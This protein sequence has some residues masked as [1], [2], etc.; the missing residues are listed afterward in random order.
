MIAGSDTTAI[1]LYWSTI[2]LA[3]YPE[4][5][6][7]MKDEVSL[8]WESTQEKPLFQAVSEST[9]MNAFIKEVVRMYPPAGSIVRRLSEEEEEIWGIPVPDQKLTTVAY[10]MLCAHRRE[11]YFPD[12]DRFWP[13]RWL[14]E[15]K[16]DSEAFCGFSQGFRACLGKNFAMI[17]LKTMFAIILKGF[18]LRPLKEG[19][20]IPLC[21]LRGQI[22]GPVEPY[23][24]K[25]IKD[26]PA[27][28]G[29]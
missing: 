23:P 22:A 20:P 16:A 19:Q 21:G 27:T 29:I 10:N 14:I 12:P 13:E 17:E 24:L 8:I 5:Q 25:L 11:E 3:H 7:K 18:H 9:Y 4:L 2:L 28:T 15:G 6:K 26:L 1:T